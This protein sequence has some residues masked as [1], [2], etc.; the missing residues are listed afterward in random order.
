MWLEIEQGSRLFSIAAAAA[1]AAA[2]CVD[3]A[4]ALRSD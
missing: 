4:P 3:P 2:V 1:A